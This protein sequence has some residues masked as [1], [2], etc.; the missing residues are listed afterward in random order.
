MPAAVLIHAFPLAASMWE[1]QLKAA[2][3]G[4]RLVA[5]D[6]R[7]FGGST[8]ADPDTDQASITDYAADVVDVLAELG[9]DRAVIGGLSMGG[10]VT[11][12]LLRRTP[13]LAT[14]VVL[15][16]TRAG[17]DSLEARATRRSLL[18]VL[19]REG[20]AGVAREV[21]PRLLGPA[22]HLD[23]P[24]LES[25]LRRLIKQQS[26][27]AI[28]GAIARLMDRPD[29]TPMLPDIRVPA[30][31]VVGSDDQVT[32]PSEA[33][34]LASE[35]PH[36]ELVVIPRSGHLSSLEQPDEFSAA[37]ARFLSRL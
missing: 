12:A 5:P 32:P 16:D 21:I 31:V 13:A 6:L 4:W 1:P 2:P 23:R 25:V 7:G 15:A 30:L 11:F 33:E 37:L 9:I 17:A 26:A 14:A 10:Y 8:A 29:S 22:A 28:R 35:I 27:E 3:A 20:A 24:D 18:A 19:E 34:R 36:A